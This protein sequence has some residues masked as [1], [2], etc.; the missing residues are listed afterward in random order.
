MDDVVVLVVKVMLTVDLVTS[1]R[2]VSTWD[3]NK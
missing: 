1:L 3:G 2:K